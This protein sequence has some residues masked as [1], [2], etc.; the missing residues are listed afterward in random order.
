MSDAGSIDL[1]T[2]GNESEGDKLER[3]KLPFAFARRFGVVLVMF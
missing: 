3:L 2:A 1:Y